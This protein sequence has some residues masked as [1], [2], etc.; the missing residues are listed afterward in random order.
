[1]NLTKSQAISEKIT[2]TN[3]NFSLHILGGLTMKK[4]FLCDYIDNIL[5]SDQDSED[6][7]QSLSKYNKFVKNAMNTYLTPKQKQIMY[8]H[9]Y[10]GQSVTQIS[11]Q[12]E[13]NKST[14]SRTLKYS[15]QKIQH[16]STLYPF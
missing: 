9:Y 5:V 11:Q 15:I 1:M 14:I 13:L 4:M 10:Q 2:V 3:N 7:H 6:N 12:L 8:M 16:L